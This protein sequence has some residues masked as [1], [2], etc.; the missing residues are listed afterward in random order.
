MYIQILKM[1]YVPT[2][3]NEECLMNIIY[4]VIRSVLELT[5]LH[6]TEN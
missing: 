1:K 6:Q 2:N 5:T 4:A 3:Q